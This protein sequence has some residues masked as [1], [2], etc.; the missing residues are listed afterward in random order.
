MKKSFS[1]YLSGLDKNITTN[2]KLE[3]RNDI[4]ILQNLTDFKVKNFRLYNVE[5]ANFD[6]QGYDCWGA[7]RDAFNSPPQ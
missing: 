5:V 3:N 1:K 6:N 2:I 7:E 4:L